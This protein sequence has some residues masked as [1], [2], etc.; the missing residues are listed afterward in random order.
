[1]ADR[2]HVD[3]NIVT[4]TDS[5]GNTNYSVVHSNVTQSTTVTSSVTT[6]GRGP[7]GIPGNDGYTPIKGV[8][9]FDGAPG[10]TDYNA[11]LNKPAL[12]TV[13]T[14]GAYDDLSGKPTIPTNNTQLTNGAGY[15]TTSDVSTG[16]ATKANLSHSHAI[17][18]TTGLQTALD[19]RAALSHSH[20]QGDVT[21]LTASLDSK[22]DVLLSG[23]S[24]KT[25]NG[26]SLLGSGDIEIS[27]GGGDSNLDGGTANTIYG[28]TTPVDG[29]TA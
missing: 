23:T 1:M 26:S 19:A 13:A 3:S 5:F 14:S 29:G 20:A 16:L 28:G 11:L 9:Y 18:D 7:Q 21:G 17:S 6:G 24:I 12:S 10:T 15:A 25:V 4:S 8:D 2:S 22:Q 27:G